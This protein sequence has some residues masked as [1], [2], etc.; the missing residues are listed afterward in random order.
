LNA[1]IS[2]T[3]GSISRHIKVMDGVWLSGCTGFSIVTERP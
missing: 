2:A 3:A 1:S